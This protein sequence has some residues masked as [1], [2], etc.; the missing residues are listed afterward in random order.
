MVT[1][2]LFAQ[3][4]CEVESRIV[5]AERDSSRLGALA[6]VITLLPALLGSISY[7]PVEVSNFTDIPVVV[8]LSQYEEFYGKRPTEFTE[9]L[10][11]ETQ[12]VRVRPGET[13]EAEF[14]RYHEWIVWRQVE[15]AV[16]AAPSGV[17]S[18]HCDCREVIFGQKPSLQPT[19]S[20]WSARVYRLLARPIGYCVAAWLVLLLLQPRWA[21]SRLW[22]PLRVAPDMRS[23]AR[24][25]LFAA[26]AI[27]VLL[28][29]V[30]LPQSAGIAHLVRTLILL[31]TVPMFATW[32]L[33]SAVRIL[34]PRSV[35]ES[36]SWFGRG[37]PGFQRRAVSVRAASLVTLL[38]AT[39]STW[40]AFHIV[41]N[42]LNARVEPNLAPYESFYSL[43]LAE[44]RRTIHAYPLDEQINIYLVGERQCSGSELQGELALNAAGVVPLLVER[45]ARMED[46][47][48]AL[49]MFDL[50]AWLEGSGSYPVAD[51]EELMQALDRVAE[52][53]GWNDA[54]LEKRRIRE[55]R[56][57]GEKRRDVAAVEAAGAN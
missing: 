1:V 55:I 54:Y 56:E 21:L 2:S 17:L 32:W 3:S 10:L 39:A 22:S 19:P 8:E 30:L 12:R 20:E 36:G 4:P 40:T 44:Q 33:A 29:F 27:V 35:L 42:R 53:P 26:V 23:V 38:I 49:H 6:F 45:L 25:R 46:R 9:D 24:Y 7:V 41:M 52:R 34:L 48:E 5:R 57:H 51:N 37:F 13:A 18:L 11:R 43:P 15:P 28:L 14:D 50:L 31:A 16:G 47:F